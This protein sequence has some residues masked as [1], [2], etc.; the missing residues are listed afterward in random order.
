MVVCKDERRGRTHFGNGCL[1]VINNIEA[2]FRMGV[3]AGRGGGE[4]V[5][6]ND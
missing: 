1:G 3:C 2:R 5:Q 4:R 6:L